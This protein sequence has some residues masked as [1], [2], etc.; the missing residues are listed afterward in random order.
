MQNYES[1]LENELIGTPREQYEW[2]QNLKRESTYGYVANQALKT[3]LTGLIG[4]PDFV[5]IKGVR[6]CLEST[7]KVHFPNEEMPKPVI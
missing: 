2:I 1:L 3:L 7:F 6:N 4:T 5:T